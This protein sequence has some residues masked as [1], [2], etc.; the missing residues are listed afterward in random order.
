MCPLLTTRLTPSCSNSGRLTGVM[1]RSPTVSVIGIALRVRRWVRSQF[2]TPS[3]P[4]L[5]YRSSDFP[6]VQLRNSYRSSI[7]LLP[8]RKTRFLCRI[9]SRI[10][11][12]LLP[13]MVL[14]NSFSS[15][16]LLPLLLPPPTQLSNRPQSTTHQE[17]VAGLDSSING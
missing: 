8:V 2:V 9:R 7:D 5:R 11:L 13:H 1:V 14:I 3:G 12:S 17:S 10:L 6:L 4:L 16:I 15:P